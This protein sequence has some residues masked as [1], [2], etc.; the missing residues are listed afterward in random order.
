MP[1]ADGLATACDKVYDRGQYLA[2][3]CSGTTLSSRHGH[4]GCEP[5]PFELESRVTVDCELGS[6]WRD[7]GAYKY[8][9][10]FLL[11]FCAQFQTAKCACGR[12]RSTV[13]CTSVYN[14]PMRQPRPFP[15]NAPPP[16]SPA[17]R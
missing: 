8:I 6:Q 12:V 11:I 9:F 7:M 3:Y 14:E 10:V 1:T 17:I 16:D 5:P 2:H 4:T 13:S 15:N